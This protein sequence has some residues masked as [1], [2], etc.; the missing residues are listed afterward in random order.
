MTILSHHDEGQ[1]QG[2]VV[3]VV[4]VGGGLTVNVVREI[5]RARNLLRFQNMLTQ[6]GVQKEVPGEGACLRHFFSC[7]GSDGGSVCST[8]ARNHIVYPYLNFLEI[9]LDL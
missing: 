3:G 9:I 4:T 2:N 8:R 7:V 1:L 5:D 6:E